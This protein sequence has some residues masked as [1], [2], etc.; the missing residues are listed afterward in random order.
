MSPYSSL[1]LGKIEL[2]DGTQTKQN[3][4]KLQVN[5]KFDELRK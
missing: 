5:L 4:K 1:A 3:G 2:L